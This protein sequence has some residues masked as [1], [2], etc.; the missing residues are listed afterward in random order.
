MKNE[1]KQTFSSCQ[2]LESCKN[3]LFLRYQQKQA[4][5]ARKLELKKN[6]KLENTNVLNSRK[7]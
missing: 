3:P 6:Q 7:G 1:L 5:Y 4:G 2:Y